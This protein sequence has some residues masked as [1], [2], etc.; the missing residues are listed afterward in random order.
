MLYYLPIILAYLLHYLPFINLML[1]KIFKHLINICQ[2]TG[3]SISNYDKK[4]W[5]LSTILGDPS[6]GPNNN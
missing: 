5:Q 3:L 1:F 2:I 6:L 4:V